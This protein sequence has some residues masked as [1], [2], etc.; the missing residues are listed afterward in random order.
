[1]SASNRDN[2]EMPEWII[3]SDYLASSTDL[4]IPDHHIDSYG[5]G[6]YGD[7]CY[8]DARTVT[9]VGCPDNEGPVDNPTIG[10]DYGGDVIDYDAE[11]Y[12]TFL[13]QRRVSLALKSQEY[14]HFRYG[15]Y[16]WARDQCFKV[17][18]QVWKLLLEVIASVCVFVCDYQ[19]PL[20]L[21]VLILIP[22][23]SIL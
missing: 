21:M 6:C 22:F 11:L 8:G 5:D 10:G 18:V 9:D 12:K 20:H 16:T 3:Q 13:L 4:F 15:R 23:T 2:I 17:N 19:S 7:G 14:S 1:M